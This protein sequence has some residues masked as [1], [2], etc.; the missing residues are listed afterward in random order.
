MAQKKKRATAKSS[1]KQNV[2]AK[3]RVKLSQAAK[4]RQRLK[5]RF[6]K[7]SFAAEGP[8]NRDKRNWKGGGIAGEARTGKGQVRGGSPEQMSKSRA[9]G[10]TSTEYKGRVT[11]AFNRWKAKGLDDSAAREAARNE[12]GLR[13]GKTPDYLD[14]ERAYTTRSTDLEK[15]NRTLRTAGWRKSHDLY[16]SRYADTGK[17]KDAL[18]VTEM[19]GQL[20]PDHKRE[21]ER[22]L[23]EPGSHFNLGLNVDREHTGRSKYAK[24]RHRLEK[25]SLALQ[26]GKSHQEAYEDLARETRGRKPQQA[27]QV[28]RAA[29]TRQQ[30]LPTRT[31]KFQSQVT[32]ET[33]K[34]F[35]VDIPGVSSVERIASSHPELSAKQALQVQH[36]QRISYWDDFLKNNKWAH[37]TR[38]ANITGGKGDVSAGNR[39]TFFT[40]SLGAPN[41]SVP[42]DSLVGQYIVKKRKKFLEKEGWS[43]RDLAGSFPNAVRDMHIIEAST[44]RSLG[45]EGRFGVYKQGGWRA[46]SKRSRGFGKTAPVGAQVLTDSQGRP[47]YDEGGNVVYSEGATR[48]FSLGTRRMLGARVFIG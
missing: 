47:I 25:Y 17:R 10:M 3:T 40:T 4:K 41:A 28:K 5:G 21:V 43:S 7:A 46:G 16:T 29:G 8:R 38:R 37:E 19:M 27:R 1:H 39:V 2:S 18:T 24:Q 30:P 42:A 20:A 12:V 31:N 11:D 14:F 34:G 23:Q 45:A 44:G 33:G 15:V 26:S 32:K 6:T 22:L 13:T 9:S 35:G 48:P 36:E